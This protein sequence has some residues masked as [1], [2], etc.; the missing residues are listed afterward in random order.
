MLSAHHGSRGWGIRPADERGVRAGRDQLSGE[1]LAVLVAGDGAEKA[2]RDVEATERDRSVEGA[3]SGDGAELSVVVDEIDERLAGCDDHRGA[4]LAA[5][6]SPEPR[7]RNVT[8]MIRWTAGAVSP[9]SRR[10][11]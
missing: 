1:H 10:K 5:G 9:S 6:I 8:G 7:A 2:D 4:G 11:S 3:A